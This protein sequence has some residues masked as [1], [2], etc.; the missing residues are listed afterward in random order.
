MDSD[1]DAREAL[2]SWKNGDLNFSKGDY[3]GSI[4]CYEKAL[5]ISSK[6]HTIERLINN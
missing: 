6:L 5:E 2:T 4:K 3:E 1:S